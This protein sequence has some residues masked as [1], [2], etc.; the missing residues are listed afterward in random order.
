MTNCY[1][2][3]VY[4]IIPDTGVSPRTDTEWLTLRVNI[5]AASIRTDKLRAPVGQA[6]TGRALPAGLTTTF[7]TLCIDIYNNQESVMSLYWLVK[8]IE[9]SLTLW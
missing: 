2:K 8:T 4:R 3:D 5:T 1:D 9:L 7:V 6:V